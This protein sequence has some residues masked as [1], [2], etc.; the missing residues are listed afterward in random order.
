MLKFCI[1]QDDKLV[2]IMQRHKD[3]EKILEAEIYPAARKQSFTEE[4]RDDDE[5]KSLFPNFTNTK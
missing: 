4:G 1:A 3:A 5:R 2:E